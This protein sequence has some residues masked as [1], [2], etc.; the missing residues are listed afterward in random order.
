RHQR[1]LSREHALTAGEGLKW[2]NPAYFL[3]TILFAFA[4]YQRHAN[5]VFTPS[6]KDAFA[7]RL[8][9]FDTGKGSIRLPYDEEIPDALLADMIAYRIREFEVDGVKW[10]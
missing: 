9:D 1:V 10:M 5:V 8:T 2:G 3:D 4:G 6:T 7:D